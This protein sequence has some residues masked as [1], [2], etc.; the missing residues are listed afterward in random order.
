VATLDSIRRRLP[1]ARRLQRTGEFAK[2]RQ[3][4]RR[5]AKGCLIA[6]WA[7]LPPGTAPRL[8]VIASRAVGG[9]VARNRA[10]RLL[11]ESF[12]LHQHQLRAPVALVLIARPSLPRRGLAGVEQDL[13]AALREG[14]LLH[15]VE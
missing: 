12:R 4:G 11:R 13:L 7:A 5:V 3:E 1:R 10:R 15:E 2:V 14:R 9:A 8:G 6:N